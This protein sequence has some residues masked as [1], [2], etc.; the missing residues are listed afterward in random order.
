M[1][2]HLPRHVRRLGVQEERELGGQV[3]LLPETRDTVAAAAAFS[4]SRRG[5]LGTPADLDAPERIRTSDLMLRRAVTGTDPRR[6][7]PICNGSRRVATARRGVAPGRCV[8][9]FVTGAFRGFE[10]RS[11]PG[12]SRL[13]HLQASLDRNTYTNH[14]Y[15]C[16]QV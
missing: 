16:L 9:G 11:G 2:D 13:A 15:R 3:P 14:Y 10:T 7:A 12:A 4:R 6:Y 5:P 8:T 1:D